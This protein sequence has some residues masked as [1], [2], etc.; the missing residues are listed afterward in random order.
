MA[1]AWVQ[2]WEESER[3][4]GTRPDGYTVHLQEEDFI[5][6]LSNMRQ[7]EM[8]GMPEGYVPE[9]YSRPIGQIFET[10][11]ADGLLPR[12]GEMGRWLPSNWKPSQ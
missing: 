2:E 4:W 5:H 10:D 3:G 9:S 12:Q 11:V 8:A 6:F 1:M 7:R